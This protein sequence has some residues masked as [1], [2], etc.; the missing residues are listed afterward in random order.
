[1]R[2]RAIRMIKGEERRQAE[3]MRFIWD[4]PLRDRHDFLA[5]ALDKQQDED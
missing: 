1:M 5:V 3:A 4:V 2:A